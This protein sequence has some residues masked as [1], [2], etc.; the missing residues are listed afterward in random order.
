MYQSDINNKSMHIRPIMR[1]R[2]CSLMWGI[3]CC[4]C[5]GDKCLPI[6]QHEQMPHITLQSSPF[7]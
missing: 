4:L 6:H 3:C 7:T 1:D 2:M 5:D